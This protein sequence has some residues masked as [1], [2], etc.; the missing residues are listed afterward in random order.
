MPPVAAPP[1]FSRSAAHCDQLMMFT[2][3]DRCLTLGL[4]LSKHHPDYVHSIYRPPAVPFP[5]S[6]PIRG[7]SLG[8]PARHPAVAWTAVPPPVYPQPTEAFAGPLLRRPPFPAARPGE[9]RSGDRSAELAFRTPRSS[10]PTSGP[11]GRARHPALGARC[12]WSWPRPVR[13][14][15]SQ[16]VR[17]LRPKQHVPVKPADCRRWL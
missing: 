8:R 5:V 16:Q 4:V 6:S 17:Q 11:G 7:Q 13:V 10:G 1:P 15:W 12:H 14:A 9:L 2:G 3:Q